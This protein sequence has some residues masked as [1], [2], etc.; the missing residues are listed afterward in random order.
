MRITIILAAIAA[1]AGV[2]GLMTAWWPKKPKPKVSDI[3]VKFGKLANTKN[4]LI[5]GGDI[6]VD[7]ASQGPR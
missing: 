7:K 6:V 5:F 1:L 3:Q 4:V 2:L